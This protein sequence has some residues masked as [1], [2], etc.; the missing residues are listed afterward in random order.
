[1]NE[2]TQKLIELIKENPD[3][4]I[5]PMVYYEV[6]GEDYGN[7]VGRFSTCYVGEYTLF[8]EKYYEDREEFEE[9]YYDYYREEIDEKFNYDPSLSLPNKP[10]GITKEQ[11]DANEIAEKNVDK[12]L[13][14]IAD[15]FFKKAIIVHIDSLD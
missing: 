10:I 11:L 6:V 3:L 12:Y 13:E 9:D 5:I 8:Y 14:E 4:P 7:W 15:G 2:K 1:M